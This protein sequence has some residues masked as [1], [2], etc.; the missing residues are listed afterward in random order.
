MQL[1]ESDSE[2]VE[3]FVFDPKI[4]HGCQSDREID[5]TFQ[6]RPLRI[7]DY[8]RHFLQLL[9]QLTTVGEIDEKSFQTRFKEMQKTGMY[10]V[11]VIEDK[12]TDKIVASTTLFLEYKFIHTNAIRARIEDVVVDE[13]VRGKGLGKVLVATAIS[14]A[15][16]LRCYK[17]SLD[18]RDQMIRFYESLGFIAIPGRANMLVI[19]L[20]E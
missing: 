3:D 18:C 5:S 17:V 8:S 19:R 14:L 9:T 1:Q 15:K 4:L 2:S 16:K 10:F 12:N 20:H 11:I 13:C 6:I 7:S